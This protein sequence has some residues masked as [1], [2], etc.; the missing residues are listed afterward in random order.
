MSTTIIVMADYIIST[1]NLVYQSL[2]VCHELQLC[3]MYNMLMI[4][5]RGE[6]FNSPPWLLH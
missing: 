1:D 5:F 3:S 2:N 6:F 4:V